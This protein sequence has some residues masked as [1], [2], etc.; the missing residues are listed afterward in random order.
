MGNIVN[1]YADGARRGKEPNFIGGWGTILEAQGQRKEIWGGLVGASNNQM[2]MTAVLEGLKAIKT[3]E[4]SIKVFS[5]SAYIVNCFRDKWYE[6]WLKNGWMTSQKK[7]VEN[8][9]MW[10]E[11]LKLVSKFTSVTFFH[12]DG[13]ISLKKP[14]EVAEFHKKFNQKNN[15]KF[16]LEEFI[17]VA[18]N[19]ARVDVLA[20]QGAEDIKKSL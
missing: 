3:N 4:A 8:K 11:I 19:N 15:V 14:D 17:H 10:L 9:Q 13:H 12:I 7:P 18:E 5:D 6:T 2:E 20:G 1:I 16:S